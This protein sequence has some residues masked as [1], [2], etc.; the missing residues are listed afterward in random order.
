MTIKDIQIKQYILDVHRK[1]C[2]DLLQSY[3]ATLWDLIVFVAHVLVMIRIRRSN[4]YYIN[5]T[6][7]VILVITSL[8]VSVLMLMYIRNREVKAHIKFNGNAG[9]YQSYEEFVDALSTAYLC[10]YNSMLA[11]LVSQGKIK[12][13]MM[14]IILAEVFLLSAILMHSL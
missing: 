4:I 3:D 10:N 14:F 11:G 8:V 12:N 13:S 6:A 2:N 9:Q 5:K 7:F 1:Q